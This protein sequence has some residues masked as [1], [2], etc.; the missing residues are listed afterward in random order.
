MKKLYELIGKVVVYTTL[1]ISAVAF[2]IWAFMQN[3][4]Y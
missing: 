2:T 4:I 3:T 1:Y